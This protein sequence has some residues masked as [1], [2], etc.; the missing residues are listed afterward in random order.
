MILCKKIKLFANCKC[1]LSE[2]PMYNKRDKM[3][4]WRGF[5]GEIYRKYI[6][7]DVDKF[8]CFPLNV[9]NI[10]SMVFTNMEDIL[11]F[12]EKG[13]V[14]KWKPGNRPIIYKDFKKSLFNDV[15][16]DKHGRIYCGM[17][18]ENY[19]DNEKRG[20]YGSLWLWNN[21]KFTCIENTIGTTPNGIRFSPDSKKMYFAVTDD[22]CIYEYKYDE[23][24]GK[25]V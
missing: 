12:G 9:G 5:R 8:E 14:W 4:Y 23:N 16:T 18:A 20:K 21:D 1:E 11:L 10:G 7:D 15:I 13:I 2:S 22:D 17:L 3:L 25:T 24:T 19:F 6:D